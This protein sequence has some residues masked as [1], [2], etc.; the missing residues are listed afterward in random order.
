MGAIKLKTAGGQH[1]FTLDPGSIEESIS[2][3]GDD[4]FS[5]IKMV[6]QKS[7]L[8]QHDIVVKQ[9]F[10]AFSVDSFELSTNT[11]LIIEQGSVYKIL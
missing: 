2:I 10:N 4:I 6:R 5:G 3:S 11:N 9:G 8:R 7:A 1:T